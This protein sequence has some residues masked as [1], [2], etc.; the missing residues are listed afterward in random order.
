LYLFQEVSDPGPAG[1]EDLDRLERGDRAALEP[2][3]R[4]LELDPIRFASGYV[5]ED[6]IRYINRVALNERGYTPAPSGSASS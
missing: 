4:Y 6:L 2:A 3:I 1:W 5:K